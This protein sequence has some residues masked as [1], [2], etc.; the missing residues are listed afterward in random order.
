[1]YACLRGWVCVAV[2]DNSG[3]VLCKVR[4]ITLHNEMRI[5]TLLKKIRELY[6]FLLCVYILTVLEI[7]KN[8]RPS[9]EF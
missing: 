4:I 2:R 5:P 7:N 6:R 8:Y 9:S 1:M 3:M